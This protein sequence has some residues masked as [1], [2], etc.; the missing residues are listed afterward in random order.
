MIIL[1]RMLLAARNRSEGKGGLS[2]R[3]TNGV[4]TSGVTANLMLFDRGTFWGTPVSLLLSPQKCQG[5][6]FS[7]N[8]SKIISFAAA[9]LVLTPFVRNQLESVRTTMAHKRVSGHLKRTMDASTRVHIGTYA[10]I[11]TCM[12]HGIIWLHSIQVDAYAHM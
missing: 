10:D 5:V 1:E 8:L 7:P 6:L 11:H 3:G 4:S 2:Q 12:H 9:P